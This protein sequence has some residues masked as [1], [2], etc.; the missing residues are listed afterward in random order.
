[1]VSGYGNPWDA[2]LR[3]NSTG[4]TSGFVGGSSIL[5]IAAPGPWEVIYTNITVREVME[6][7]G[8]IIVEDAI[9]GEIVD[10]KNNIY[11]MEFNVT[12]LSSL[13]HFSV[14]IGRIHKLNFLTVKIYNATNQAGQPAPHVE[15][16]QEQYTGAIDYPDLLWYNYSFLVGTELD[17]AKTYDNAFFI[18]LA[19]DC[20]PGGAYEWGYVQDSAGVDYGGAYIYQGGNWLLQDWDFNLK[21][22]LGGPKNPS[23]IDLRINGTAIND[24][25]AYEGEWISGEVYSDTDGFVS[26]EFSA[27]TSAHFM[28]EWFVSYQMLA[29]EGVTTEFMGYSSNLVILWNASYQAQFISNSFDRYLE[30]ELPIWKS[31]MGVLKDQVAHGSWSEAVNGQSRVFVI[32]EADDATW[33][34][35]CNDT[36]YV[37]GVHAKR[38]GIIVSSINSTDSIQVFGSFSEVLSSGDA[39]LTIFPIGAGYNDTEGEQV[40]YNAT[41]QFSPTI[42]LNDT[43]SSSYT[44]AKLQ[45]VWCNGT[46][47]GINRTVLTVNQVPTNITYITHTPSVDTGESVFV[48]VNY[49]NEY[50]GELLA[51]PS[52]IVKN[53]SDNTLWPAPYQI[54]KTFANGTIQLEI[55]TLGVSGGLHYLSINLSK[56]LYL[57]D[58]LVNISVLIGGLSSNVSVTHPNCFGLDYINQSFALANPAPYAG[59]S[60]RV[61]IYYFDNATLDPLTS[62]IITASWVGGGP[63]IGWVPAYFGYYNVTIDVNGFKAG[64]THTLKI[65]IQQAGYEKA[66]LSIIVQIRKLPTTIA[67]EQTSYSKYLEESFT[68][69]AVFEDNY[70]QQSIPDLYEL[71]GNFTIKI[72]N[73]IDNMS[74]VMPSIGL[75]KYDLV[76][77]TLG[78]EEGMTYNI[79]LFAFS[80]EHEFSL[81][82]VS[83]YVIPKIDISLAL[84]GIPDFILAGDQFEIYANLTLTEGLPIINT[85]LKFRVIY[86]AG[87]TEYT[88]LTNSSGIAEFLVESNPSADSLRIEVVYS[89]NMTVQN[90][91]ISSE[92]IPIIIL[93][94]SLT[95]SPL[96]GEIRQGTAL[97]V[98]ATLLIG[99]VPASD[100]LVT[101]TFTYEGSDQTDIRSGV[102]DSSGVAGVS[103]KLPSG[104]SRVYVTVQYAGVTAV[105]GNETS[106]EASVIS[107]MTLVWRYAPIWLTTILAAVGSLLTYKYVYKRQKMKKLQTK[108]QKAT[109]RYQDTDNLEFLLIISKDVGISLYNYSF[110]GEE[111]DFQLISGFLTAIGTFQKEFKVPLKSSAL[112]TGEWDINYQEFKIH[113]IDR[114]NVQFVFVLREKVSADLK[115]TFLKYSMEVERE[116]NPEFVRFRGDVGVFR[117]IDNI[118]ERYFDKTIFQPLLAKSLSA[119]QLK[120]L[121]EVERRLYNLAT[122]YTNDQGYF[123]VQKLLK[124][125]EEMLREERG[126]IIAAIWNLIDKDYFT[127]SRLSL[128]LD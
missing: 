119:D 27:N 7:T 53:S 5:E 62:G 109:V 94:S 42:R 55:L 47:A 31:V 84:I 28:I 9:S 21:V 15:L 72:G 65:Q 108:W 58:E 66:E 76:L 36:N 44:E 117:G 10:V 68:L 120:G 86:A 32:G 3:C 99:G 104:V 50:T 128:L 93:N 69:Y 43:A 45:I 29:D 77:S 64:T 125:A 48:F 90:Q 124:N 126:Q 112:R 89:G 73:L 46:A 106:A 54:A 101:F 71:D 34:I 82:E 56:P 4:N 11:A 96:P 102:T 118:T 39:N 60:V 41:V 87:T 111:L 6:E 78:I 107:V 59:S 33:T 98:N 37:S 22:G 103:I 40:T 12:E 83:L 116:F 74:K 17:P 38:D 85:P 70:N 1:M 26:F 80:S 30:I 25:N 100:E 2:T 123:Y 127:A 8:L 23:E 57:S 121:A 95:L 20:G 35:L 51:A 92:D 110:R 91:T 52:L 75:Y 97:E 67:P 24:T 115:Q 81:I 122:S 13:D 61:G 18:E 88:E 16:Y 19:A 14:Y 114:E 79:T 49:T 63:T 113:G 105:F